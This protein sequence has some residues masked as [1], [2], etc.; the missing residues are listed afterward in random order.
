MKYAGL[1]VVL[2]YGWTVFS[3]FEPFPVGKRQP[4][5]SSSALRHTTGGGLWWSRG[6]QGGK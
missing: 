6:F 1:L 5:G 2:L 3:G 4:V